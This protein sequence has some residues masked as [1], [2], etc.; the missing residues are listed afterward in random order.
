MKCLTALAAAVLA[1]LVLTLVVPY[2]LVPD[3][4]TP[5]NKWANQAAW[6]DAM[7]YWSRYGNPQCFSMDRRG[8]A[9]WVGS[10][11][12]SSIWSRVMITDT[13][14]KHLS[15]TVDVDLPSSGV[16]DLVQLDKAIVY[17]QLKKQ[18]T[19]QCH[20]V[21]HAM[22]MT[23]AAINL[24]TRHAS[25]GDAKSAINQTQR[26]SGSQHNGDIKLGLISAIK[27]TE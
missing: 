9:V 8:Y 5:Y 3:T 16:V 22:L 4:T 13:Q 15:M 11:L 6:K 23:T 19:V 20:D 21:G 10:A 2:L 14:P 1:I 12:A 18:L 7:S 17:N 25:M 24:A 26:D 27:R